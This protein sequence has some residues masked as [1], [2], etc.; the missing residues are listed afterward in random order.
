MVAGAAREIHERQAKERMS[1]G[2]GD[3]KSERAKSGTQNS[4][5][6]I[7]KGETRPIMGQIVGVSGFSVDCA[8]KV[9]HRAVPELGRAERD[10]NI[11]REPLPTA[12]LIALGKR[13]EALEKPKAKAKQKPKAKERKRAGGK[14]GGQASGKL[15]EASAGQ[16][17]D[18]VATA[19]GVSGR[20]DQKLAAVRGSAGAPV[21]ISPGRDSRPPGRH[22]TGG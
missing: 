13:I 20:T 5:Y 15:P 14:A 17:R 3:K 8:T 6:P 4:A 11:A 22:N 12:E 1:K 19:V 21:R 2:G 10:E 18:R 7:S 16:T 9:L